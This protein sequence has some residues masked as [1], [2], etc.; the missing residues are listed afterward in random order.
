MPKRWRTVRRESRTSGISGNQRG[1]HSIEIGSA[2][3]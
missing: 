3:M 1:G 2:M